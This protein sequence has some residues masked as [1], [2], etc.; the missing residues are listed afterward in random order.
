MARGPCFLGT[1][2]IAKPALKTSFLSLAG[3]GVAGPSPARPQHQPVV[4]CC[5]FRFVRHQN[6][7]SQG[8][9]D[10]GAAAAIG[11]CVPVADSAAWMRGSPDWRGGRCVRLC[12]LDST[13]GQGFLQL[14]AVEGV[15]KDKPCIQLFSCSPPCPSVPPP[16]VRT[17]SRMLDCPALKAMRLRGAHASRGR[18]CPQACS[19]LPAT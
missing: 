16:Q 12:A 8:E 14:P 2:F 15:G 19:L 17:R 4:G 10:D 9:T 7:R 13:H 18:R 3:G 1:C 6:R 11:D 5:A